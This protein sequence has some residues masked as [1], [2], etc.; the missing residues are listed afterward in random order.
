MNDPVQAQ[1]YAEAD[2]TAAHNAFV[3]GITETFPGLHPSR[4]LDL[5][6]GPG[7]ICERL[8]RCFPESHIYAVDGAEA[9]LNIA[10]QRAEKRGL[11]NRIEYHLACLPDNNLP[12]DSDLIVSNSLLHHMKDPMDLWYTVRRCSNTGTRVYVMDLVR[13]QTTAIAKQLVETYAADEADI[14]K[15]DFYHSLLAAYTLEEVEQQLQQAG[16]TDL[17]VET[18]SD[19]HMLVSGRSPE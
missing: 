9:M 7:D 11:A 12:A 8:T 15:H 10:R 1:A 3:D 16:M 17:K 6:C 14:L 5:G 18:T 2:F 4:I 13:P 19:R